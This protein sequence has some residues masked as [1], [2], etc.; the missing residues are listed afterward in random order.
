M[1]VNKVTEITHYRP[2]VIF[3]FPLS[4]DKDKFEKG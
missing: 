3:P 1:F 4:L 2:S